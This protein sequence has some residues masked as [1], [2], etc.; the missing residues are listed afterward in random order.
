[1]VE[2][3]LVVRWATGYYTLND[4]FNRYELANRILSPSYVSFQSALFYAG[5]N[6]QARGEVGSVALRGLWATGRR[7]EIRFIPMWR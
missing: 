6:F 1:M 2:K 3:G 5:I 7:S 4:R